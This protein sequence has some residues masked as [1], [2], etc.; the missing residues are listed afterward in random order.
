MTRDIT[1]QELGKKEK[2]CMRNIST[3]LFAKNQ[4]IARFRVSM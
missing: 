4:E 1:N 3:N 2:N